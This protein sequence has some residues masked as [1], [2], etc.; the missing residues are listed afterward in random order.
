MDYKNLSPELREKAKA[1][2]SPEEVLELARNEGYE[3]TEGELAGIAGGVGWN[4]K[5]AYF[6]DSRKD[7][8]SSLTHADFVNG[9]VDGGEGW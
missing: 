5:H 3:L 1:C 4:C 9:V 6:G 7:I 8:D 2:T